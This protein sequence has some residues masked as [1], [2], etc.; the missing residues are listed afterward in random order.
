MRQL[1]LGFLKVL[2]GGHQVLQPVVA[3]HPILVGCSC[4]NLLCNLRM[5]LESALHILHICCGHVFDA[6]YAL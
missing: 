1:H 5:D 2:V 4:C 3:V 6:P